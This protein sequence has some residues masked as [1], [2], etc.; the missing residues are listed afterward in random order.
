MK[1][2]DCWTYLEALAG[3]RPRPLT[4]GA[5]FT[6]AG[7]G[8]RHVEVLPIGAGHARVVQ[9]GHGHLAQGTGCAL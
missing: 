2:A 3:T 9:F 5:I 7:V 1:K 4:G 6:V 8:R